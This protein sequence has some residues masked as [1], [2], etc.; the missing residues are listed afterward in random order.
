MTLFSDLS[1]KMSA[2][3]NKAKAKVM[4]EPTPAPLFPNNNYNNTS[5][6]G[7]RRTAK[8]KGGKRRTAKKCGGSK[9]R[10]SKR[11]GRKR[12]GRKSKRVRFSKRNKVYTIHK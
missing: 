3:Y 2:V 11:K 9:R 8:K 10:G 12:S 5:V 1:D 6:G 7:K 4:G